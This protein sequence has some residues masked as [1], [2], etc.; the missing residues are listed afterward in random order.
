MG[1]AGRVEYYP[2]FCGL[3]LY[4]YLYVYE[5]LY[6]CLQMYGCMYGIWMDAFCRYIEFMMS[7][8]RNKSNSR[9]NPVD[10]HYIYCYHL[11]LLLLLLLLLMLFCVHCYS[12]YFFNRRHPS[13]GSPLSF[14]SLFNLVFSFHFLPLPPTIYSLH[15]TPSLR[16]HH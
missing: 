10:L 11:L 12:D 15:T 8:Q 7:I 2:W 1:R 16:K 14:F 5:Y 9:I 4:L 13:R 3:Y 6:L